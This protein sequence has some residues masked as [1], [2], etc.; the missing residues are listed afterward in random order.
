[1]DQF[2]TYRGEL[3]AASAAGEV[4][5]FVTEH[6]E[7]VPTAL[8]R[9]DTATDQLTESALPCGGRAVAV[10]GNV[11][12][13]GGS[14][15][16]VY[17][18]DGTQKAK[19]LGETFDAPVVAILAVADSRIAL[20]SGKQ[21]HIIAE[22][23]TRLQV[24]DLP[25]AGTALAVDPSG[26]WLAVG[27]ER[28]TVAVFD[29]QDK[30]EFEPGDSAKL[31]DGAVTAIVFEP[32]ELRF[33]STGADGKLLTTHA[34]GEL[35]AEDKGRGNAHAEPVAAVILMPIG[36]RLISGGRDKTLKNWPRAGAIKP[37]TLD[38]KVGRVVALAAVTAHGVTRVAAL[39]DDTSIRLIPLSDEGRFPEEISN[40]QV[41]RGALAWARNEL[42]TGWDS[43]RRERALKQLA[44]WGDTACLD[45]I[46]EQVEKDQDSAV[47]VAGTRLLGDSTSLRAATLLEPLVN[48][49]EPKVRSAAFWGLRRRLGDDDPRPIDLALAG[50]KPEVGV[51]AIAELE[52]RGRSDDVA[53]AKIVAALDAP[54]W[55][56]RRRAVEAVEDVHVN[57]PPRAIATAL[58][59]ASAD[60]RVLALE[61]AFERK[62]LGDS[63]V[64]AAVRRR[65]EDDDA[66]VRKVAFLLSLEARPNLMAALRSRDPELHRQLAELERS[67]QKQPAALPP[68]LDDA[69]YDVLLQLTASRPLDTCLR[70]ANGLARLGD[71]RAFP[72]LLQLS[73]EEPEYAR[74][75]V[76][77]ALAALGDPRAANRLRSM[78]SDKAAAVRDAAYTAV[79][80]LAPDAL[81][82]AEAGLTAP[83]EDVRRRGLETLLAETRKN[84][85]RDEQSPGGRLF[86]R[87][88]NDPAQ[89][90]RREA[91]KAALNQNIAGGGEATLRFV[92]K[93][94]HADVRRE[95][96]NEV[97]A[98]AVE[99]YATPLLYE[100]FDDPD[101]GLRSEAFE[102]A[103]KK[104]KELEPLVAALGSRFADARLLA[105]SALHRKHSRAAQ[106]VIL[107]A[108][109][110]A[111]AGVR[112]KAV[113]ALVD[114][115]ARGPL[116]EALAATHADARVRAAAALARLG[117]PAAL[118]VLRALAFA[119]EP[120]EQ[121][122]RGDWLKLAE[123]ALGGLAA[124]ADMSVFDDLMMLIESK[125]DTLRAGASAALLT[126]TPP[127]GEARVRKLLANA[128]SNIRRGAALT[129]AARGDATVH[130]V[131]FAE[132]ASDADRLA[133]LLAAE[134]ANRES[135]AEWLDAGDE[136]ARRPA[137]LAHLLLE[138][139]DTDGVPDLLLQALAA[140]APRVR[141]AAA[142]GL[143]TFHDPVAFAE[144]VVT[145]ANDRGDDTDWKLKA[146]LLDPLAAVL[147]F[148]S[149]LK[150]FEAGR[151]LHFFGE[152]ESA[153]LRQEWELFAARNKSVV[154]E[155]SAELTVTP[156]ALRAAELRELA[157]GA[158]VG[159]TREQGSGGTGVARVRQTALSRVSAIAAA[160]ETYK[161]SARPVF[162]QALADP[163]QVV[164]LQAFDHLQALGLPNSE[165]GAEA[166]ESGSTDLGVRGLELLTDGTSSKEGEAVLERVMLARTDDIATESAKLL[167][168]SRG[169]TTVATLAL[170]AVHE[171][172]RIQAVNWLAGDY[173]DEPAAKDALRAA[174]QSRYRRIREEAAYALS[175]KRDPAAFETLGT[176]LREATDASRQTRLTAAFQRLGDKRSA[177]VLLDRVETDPTGT[178][179]A[180]ELITAAGTFREESVSE[181]LLA[182]AARK[183]EWR[184]AAFNA[185]IAISGF[186]QDA[187]DPEEEAAFAKQE[188]EQFPRRPAIL[189]R[190]IEAVNAVGEIATY[191]DLLDAPA[192]AARTGEVDAPLATLAASS[193]PEIRVEALTAIGWRAKFR[194]GPVDALLKA[195]RHKDPKTQFAAAEGLAKNR[196]SEG[197]QVLLSG[198]EYVDDVDL[199]E[200][201]VVALG[202]LADPRSVDTLLK[203]AAEEGHALQEAAAEAIGHLG[204]SAKAEEV[205]KTLLRLAKSRMS[206][207][208]ARAIV[209]LRYLDSIDGWRLVRTLAKSRNFDVQLAACEQ[210]GYNDDPATRA[211]LLDVMRTAGDEDIFGA[212]LDSARRLFGPESVEPYYAALTVPD[213]AEMGWEDDNGIDPVDF[214]CDKGDPL[215]LLELFPRCSPPVQAKIEASLSGRSEVPVAEAAEALKHADDATVR[216]AARLLAGASDVPKSVGK[217]VAAAQTAW[218]AQWQSRRAEL[219]RVPNAAR[220]SLEQAA[221]ALRALFWAGS[222]LGAGSETV[223]EVA[224]ARPGDRFARPLRLI[225]L[226]SLGSIRDWS[227][228]ATQAVEACATSD[229]PEARTLAAALLARRE[230]KRAM[231]L[232]QDQLSDKPTFARAAEASGAAL[233]A[234]KTA[235]AKPDQ[236]SVALP[237][238]IA[239]KEI[240]L[241]AKVA[242]EA[243]S[244]LPTRLGAIEGLGAMADLQ[245]EKELTDLAAALK[246][247]KG[248]SVDVRK[249]AWKAVR[250]SRR[251]RLKLEQTGATA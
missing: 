142:Q 27:S 180:N 166:L 39:C 1:M 197:M 19:P 111:D 139:A 22:D 225:A 3:R 6:P 48:H 140:R 45:L 205:S 170:E 149:P 89:P 203:L 24:F 234:A 88:L 54:T 80:R 185:V 96:L 244:P 165:L 74:V 106:A 250:R 91:L 108:V 60:V 46:A 122:R 154:K 233:E 92:L 187:T 137:L 182:M 14:N 95:V 17:V 66:T 12:Y 75:E 128:D 153:Q 61:R 218:Y 226:R 65:L 90:V 132:G 47:R 152:K 227:Q 216:L 198:I 229:D 211:L 36:D 93:S 183:K 113:A 228:S 241:L 130:P 79:A 83:H 245:A 73:R 220:G 145:T 171:P 188:R 222:R 249:A 237:V 98:R 209:G 58:S 26:T 86:V 102:Q 175:V 135:L 208:A 68:K 76:C 202:E 56:V 104:N 155:S 62:L 238:L 50:G 212:A 196:R 213:I 247:A 23:G 41:W 38:G 49:F 57:D 25:D 248:D 97:Q 189:A 178:A 67:E 236:Q 35:E 201:A 110:D 192:R 100:F 186:D 157:F 177:G 164:R 147:A 55:E 146:E 77:R 69:D 168:K 223:A 109:A 221:A 16:R 70:G 103:T 44:E 13:V 116:T 2:S 217:A 134:P 169:T 251:A 105:I 101:P 158:Y 167:A 148:A 246:E 107:K 40:Y 161:R 193:D 20:A 72:L 204:K 239:A 176:L 118:P 37:V 94:V 127:E 117:D 5:S 151:L 9:L 231:P 163:N 71:P 150:R 214:A 224:A 242:A 34:R 172:L 10:R 59:A 162:T 190:L 206:G 143:E 120:A 121:Y 124:L 33:F 144:F 199:R 179:S 240:A 81:A 32:E 43:K 4:L 184:A 125:T 15:G 174:V 78:L 126:C 29:S 30:P 11:T 85:P 129:L 133:V 99:N 114:D 195:L 210:L 230:P 235:A 115:D 200:R 52:K 191:I 243:K 112:E 31:H 156:S 219:E 215:R 53:L 232:V 194:A 159:L 64:L 21:L 131:L 8:Y 119:P 141:L 18:F 42:S 123:L 82:A 28:G 51:L 136:A 138:R 181:R 173:D 63:A 7:G 207:V 84:P 87:A 160:D